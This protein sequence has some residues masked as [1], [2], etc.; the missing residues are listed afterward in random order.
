VSEQE[1]PWKLPDHVNKEIYQDI[2]LPRALEGVTRPE[3]PTVIFIGGQAASSK[4]TAQR[5]ALSRLGDEGGVIADFDALLTDHPHY[6]SL[7]AQNDRTAAQL[8]GGDAYVWMQNLIQHAKDEQLNLIREGSMGGRSAER[9]ALEF[10]GRGF[11]TE[12]DVMAVP[13]AISRTANL[14]RYQDMR[15]KALYGRLVTTE[16]HDSAYV[17]IPRTLESLEQNKSL[18][19]IRL[20]RWGGGLVYE[21]SLNAQGEWTRPAN[22]RTALEQERLRPLDP[23]QAKWLQERHAYLGQRLPVELR[24]QLREIEGL[25]QQVGVQLGDNTPRSIA[26]AANLHRSTGQ[27]ARGTSASE[28]PGAGP[29]AGPSAPGAAIAPGAAAPRVPNQPPADPRRSR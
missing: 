17:G 13:A 9:E 21:N 18:D 6:A 27:G 28:G 4:T 26:A 25:A 10:R 2:I 15:E 23:E 19:A 1:N 8:A 16:I 22:A 29:K 7:M 5:T 20:H 3:Q 12:A 24:G 14:H 11:G